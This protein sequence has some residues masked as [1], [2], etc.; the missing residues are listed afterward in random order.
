MV[1]T[2]DLKGGF[3]FQLVTPILNPPRPS[4]SVRD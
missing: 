3:K 1:F 2:L 4:F